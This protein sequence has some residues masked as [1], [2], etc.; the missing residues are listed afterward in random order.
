MCQLEGLINFCYVVKVQ[1]LCKV[2]K[3]N[4]DGAY[5]GIYREAKMG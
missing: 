3:V 5:I 2:A 1:Y 4:T